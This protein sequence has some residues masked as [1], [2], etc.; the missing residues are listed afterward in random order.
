MIRRSSEHGMP[1]QPHQTPNE[2]AQNLERHLPEVNEDVNSITGYFNEA[3][4]SRHEITAQHAGQV[5]KYW[6]RIRNA[7]RKTLRGER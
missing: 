7:L 6:Q 3:R 5:Q 1:R 4:Y 2:Y